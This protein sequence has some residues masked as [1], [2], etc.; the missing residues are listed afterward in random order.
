MAGLSARKRGGGSVALAVL[1][2]GGLLLGAVVG[3]FGPVRGPPG[4][5]STDPPRTAFSSSIHFSDEFG[6]NTSLSTSL[7]QV[8]GPAAS[9]SMS[10]WGF[11][12]LT[13]VHPTLS[14]APATGL[15]FSGVADNY[16]FANVQS[17]PA[18]EPP[19]DLQAVG[20]ATVSNGNPIA[21]GV[22]TADGTAGD[23]IYCNCGE[24]NPYYGIGASVS[25][26]RGEPW[27]G[28]ETLLSDPK[29]GVEYTFNINVN[30]TGAT[31][32]SISLGSDLLGS[33]TTYT[34]SGAYYVFLGQFVDSP[35]PGNGPNVAEW[36]Y[37]TLSGSASSPTTPSSAN[38][39]VWAELELAT[40]VGAI[41]LVLAVVALWVAHRR[42]RP[43]PTPFE[44]GPPS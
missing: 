42:H 37:V 3:T 32:V 41:A 23:A 16:T 9:A 25:V 39:H 12:P 6:L 36:Q 5:A 40:G 17:I 22:A 1:V 38:T 14:F 31:V 19:F 13:A 10:N 35:P 33:D 7:W 21:L 4:A 11:Y 29:L 30:Q 27:D 20:M 18:F 44:M 26:G 34:P 43:P 15:E 28:L 2:V 8:D 24:T